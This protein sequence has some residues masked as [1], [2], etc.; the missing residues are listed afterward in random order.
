MRLWDCLAPLSTVWDGA[1]SSP[2]PGA[3][4]CRHKQRSE[5]I[6]GPILFRLVQQSVQ[7]RRTYAAHVSC[8]AHVVKNTVEAAYRRSDL[9]EQRSEVMDAWGRCIA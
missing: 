1:G 4:R 5:A 9:L 3:S 7:L 2:T 8:L 6:S